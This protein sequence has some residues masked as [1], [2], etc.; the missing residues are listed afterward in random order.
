MRDQGVDVTVA[1]YKRSNVLKEVILPSRECMTWPQAQAYCCKKYGG[2]LWEPK[3]TSE[4]QS[5]WEQMKSTVSV[6]PSK[7]WLKLSFNCL[8]FKRLDHSHPHAAFGSEPTTGIR[9][10]AMSLI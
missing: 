4:L 2:K 5:V 10:T 9:Q 6:L 1:K 8:C 7:L 3:D